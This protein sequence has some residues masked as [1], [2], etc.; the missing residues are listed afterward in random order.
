MEYYSAT[1]NRWLAA[2]IRVALKP[3]TAVMRYDAVVTATKQR[4]VDVPLED[5]RRP[6]RRNEAPGWGRSAAGGR[7]D[8]TNFA[9]YLEV[10]RAVGWAVGQAVGREGGRAGGRADG[11]ADGW[12]DG[13]ADGRAE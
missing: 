4:R 12:A 8:A 3:S 10:I 13:R 5:L 6:M 9:A 7:A 1:L 11:R 2:S